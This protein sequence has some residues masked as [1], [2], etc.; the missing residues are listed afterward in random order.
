MALDYLTIPG[1][2]L[3]LCSTT[4]LLTFFILFIATSVAVERVFSQGRIL[5]SHLRNHLSVQ[6]T[7][8]LMCVGIWSLLG[9]M[10]DSDIRAVVS[11]PG[12][13]ANKREG[14]LVAGWDMVN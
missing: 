11:L 13:P 9:F 6:S 14:C 2:Y 5:L 10:E 7:R 1:M 12:V 4:A 3:K 8:A